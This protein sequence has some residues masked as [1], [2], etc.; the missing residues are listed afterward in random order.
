MALVT[1]FLKKG[2]FTHSGKLK[3]DHIIQSLFSFYFPWKV[4]VTEA[5]QPFLYTSWFRVTPVFK[6]KQETGNYLG[7]GDINCKEKQGN[8]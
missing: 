8:I 5:I 6:T 7:M 4:Y 1:G 3:Q 2:S